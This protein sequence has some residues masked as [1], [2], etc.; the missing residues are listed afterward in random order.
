MGRIDPGEGVPRSALPWPYVAILVG[1][2][3]VLGGLAAASPAAP[4]LTHERGWL[5]C[6]SMLVMQLYCSTTATPRWPAPRVTA[7]TAC[8]SPA[9]RHPP[10]ARPA[11]PRRTAISSAALHRVPHDLIVPYGPRVRSRA[12]RLSARTPPGGAAVP[13]VPRRAPAPHREPR[14]PHLSRRSASRLQRVRLRRLPPRR[15]LANRALRSRPH[16]VSAHRP[17]P[18]RLVRRLPHQPHLDRRPRR[19][20]RLSRLRPAADSGPPHHDHLR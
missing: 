7:P 9:F 1:E 10:R 19:L 8:G 15:P 14:M 18:H 6:G 4:P 13:C 20:R 12:H 5:G 2:S 17:P 16:V 3:V 11:T